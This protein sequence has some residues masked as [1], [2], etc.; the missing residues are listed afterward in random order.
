MT[1]KK[2]SKKEMP[3]I[4]DLFKNKNDFWEWQ[5]SEKEKLD[6]DFYEIFIENEKSLAIAGAGS[7]FFSPCGNQCVIQL[8]DYNFE[9][10]TIYFT[11]LPYGVLESEISLI[12]FS[13]TQAKFFVSLWEFL[14][15]CYNYNNKK[16]K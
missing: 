10:K 8:V 9:G 7:L 16:E 15:K 14:R 2:A 12:E 3:E 4:Q 5:R 1:N 13:Q 11:L 6:D